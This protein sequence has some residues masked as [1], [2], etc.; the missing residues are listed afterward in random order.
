MLNFVRSA[1]SI[2]VSI[3]LWIILIGFTVFGFF[4]F[5]NFEDDTSM[6]I[7]GGILGLLVGG[8]FIVLWGGYVA[9]FLNMGNNLE[10]MTDDFDNLSNKVSSIDEK[11]EKIIKQMGEN[12]GIN[13]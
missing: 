3:I 11:L 13:C 2:L 1:F 5:K 8:I 6:G 7:F 9:T 10:E 4:L 12:K